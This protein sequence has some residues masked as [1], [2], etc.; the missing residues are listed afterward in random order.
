MSSSAAPSSQHPVAVRY[1]R[2][3]DVGRIVFDQPG[4]PVNVMNAAALADLSAA[5]DAAEAD[6]PAVLV[7]ASAK[8]GQFIAGADVFEMTGYSRDELDA[9][10]K[11][12]QEL[13]KRIASFSAPTVAAIGGAALGGG[14]EIALAC[15]Y[16]VAAEGRAKIGLPEVTLGLIPAWGGCVRLPRRIGLEPAAQLITSGNLTDPAE[17]KRL[18]IVDETAPPDQLESTAIELARRGKPTAPAASADADE[19]RRVLS[20]L[21]QKLEEG[22]GQHYPAPIRA[23]EV[24]NTAFA[25]GEQAGFDAERQGLCDLR[26]TPA[27][28]NLLRIFGMKQNAK[29]AATSAAGGKPRELKNVAVIGGGTMGAGIA[30]VLLGT[31]KLPVTLIETDADRA[32]AARGRIEGLFDGDVAKGRAKPDAAAEAK[33]RLNATADLSGLADA[34]LVVEAAFEDMGV[35]RELFGRLDSASKPTAVLATNTSSL[36]VTEIAQA[37][38]DP[39]RV[40]GLHYFNPVPRMALVEVVKTSHSDPGA[41]ATAVAAATA[42]GK[43]PVVVND[44]PGFVVNRVLFPYLYEAMLA[45]A[46]GEDP[47]AIDASVRNWGMPMGPLELIDTIGLDVT[48]NICQA[49]KPSLAPRVDVPPGLKE[50]VAAGHLGRKSGGGFFRYEGGKRGSPMDEVVSLLRAGGG[51]VAA[52]GLPERVILPM[53]NESARVVE[54]G[55]VD[56]TDAIDLATLLGLGL[57]PFRGGV[58]RYIDDEGAEEIVRELEMLAERHGERFEPAP[59]LQR[60][61]E[62][63]KPLSSYA[64]AGGGR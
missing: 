59:L 61:A 41:V 20:M 28:Q 6:R 49:M 32:A 42:C 25:D 31:A 11:R 48:L 36:S 51:G 30:Y 54:E 44:A 55:V 58:A 27:G 15:D 24:I 35:K 63:G 1:E 34:D 52:G 57:A 26:D 22:S 14:L 29:R 17:A 39:K 9:Y 53:V 43:T 19:R 46:E 56:S 62:E 37:T 47:E 38:K 45:V 33:A 3:D 16:R 2:V 5:L 4:K 23:L 12:G 60:A 7:L 18:G 40:V 21:R 8:P 10:L 13:T 64:T 50:A